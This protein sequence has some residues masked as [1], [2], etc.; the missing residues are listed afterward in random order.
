[1]HNR[2]IDLH[3]HSNESDGT[4]TPEE[5]VYEA[6]KIGLS[7][8]ALTDHDTVSGVQKA[9]SAAVKTGV[10]VISGIE[11]STEY[12]GKEVH[13]LGLFID[14]SNSEFLQ[15]IAYFRQS[16]IDRNQKM[17]ELLRKKG[18]DITEEAVR[19]MFPDSVLTRA[20]IARY[21]YEKKYI[22]SI[23]EAF[24]R[25]IGDG[26]S[27][28]VAREKVTPAQAIRII[29]KVGG[30]AILAHPV[31]YHLP[32]STLDSLV[33]YC[34]SSGLDGIEAIYSTY[35]TSDEHDMRKLA[36]KYGLAIS[37]GSDFHGSNKPNIALG[38]GLGHLYIPYSILEA[39]TTVAKQR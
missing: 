22:K 37:G 9:K 20:H 27:C 10:T 3:V 4:F 31:L 36:K 38:Y 34:S 25:Y 39:L 2:M 19:A 24:E 1:M 28:F 13:I 5:L 30:I 23:N 16:R 8:I 18:F 17:Y 32:K 12:Q 33:S 29:H 11:L 7:A 6:D 26:K 21:M 14:E 35:Q 15:K